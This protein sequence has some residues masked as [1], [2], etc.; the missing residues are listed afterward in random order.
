[1]V[2]L[3]LVTLGVLYCFV[4]LAQGQR[5]PQA[6][7][8]SE[9]LTD[10]SEGKVQEVTISGDKISGKFANPDKTQPKEFYCY[11]RK[12]M[13]PSPE[14]VLA[15]AKVRFEEKDSDTSPWWPYLIQTIPVLVIGGVLFFIFRQAQ[16]G[17]GQA[18]SFGRS[19]H[20][21]VSENRVKVTFDDVAGVTEAKEELAEVVDYLKYPKKYQSLGARIPKGVLLLGAPGTGKTLLGRAIAG[22]AGVPFYY[23][24]GSDFVEMFVGVGASRVR[25]LFDQA[26]KTSPC[27]VFVDE[28]DAV[29][30]QR[31]AGLG[32]GHDEREQTLNQLLVEMDGF[33]PNINVIVLAATNRPDVLDPALLRPGRFDRQV[34]VD[35]PDIAGRMAILKVHSRGKPLGANVDINLLARQTPGFSGADLENLLNE[36]A[37]L[38][39][40]ANRDKVYMSDCEEAI[41]RVRMGPE[42]KSLVIPE[43]ERENTAYHEAGH[44]MVA[45]AIPE[46]LPVRKVT[47]LPRGM[48]MGVTVYAPLEDRYCYSREE[49]QA[50]IAVAMGGR[51]A[52]EIIFNKVT[53]GASSDIETAT[54][55]ARDMV[56]RYGMS[57]RLGPVHFGR[58]QSQVFLGRD[59]AE[60]RIYS[61]NVA[62]EID[63]E[64]REL[65]EDQF[66]RARRILDSQRDLLEKLATELIKS[67]ILDEEDLD[68]ILGPSETQKARER[69]VEKR[70]ISLY[71]HEPVSEPIAASQPVTSGAP[72]GSELGV[73]KS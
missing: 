57:K 37:L 50:Q 38:A 15:K 52:E 10:I 35:K 62:N 59:I 54:R 64:V 12:E 19:K 36:A 1:M 20:K 33:E 68:R 30:R 73:A 14:D 56:C 34:V 70:G 69:A 32:G 7:K 44:A 29:G 4:E 27:I 25:D 28:I 5:S 17:G 8:Y 55:L 58:K 61:E 45:R 65:I 3:F 71:P 47:I 21:L 39:A 23:I 49:L 43:D 16:S 67:E 51:A 72:A 26:K 18:F 24:S 63:A 60:N 40:R 66:E 11:F 13:Q 6:L 48:A 46:A 22:E 41:D 42:R 53:T 31:G 2:V 9:F